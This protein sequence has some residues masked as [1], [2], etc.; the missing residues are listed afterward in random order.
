MAATDSSCQPLDRKA[1]Q[2]MVSVTDPVRSTTQRLAFP[3]KVTRTVDKDSP[4]CRYTAEAVEA[5]AV[6]CHA[7]EIVSAEA[8]LPVPLSV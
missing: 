2:T 7:L 8:G 6:S 1:R 4:R 3:P 5:L